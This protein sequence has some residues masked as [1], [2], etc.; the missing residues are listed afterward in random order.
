[1]SYQPKLYSNSKVDMEVAFDDLAEI[2]DMRKIDVER[3]FY[4][5]IT[6]FIG[7]EDYWISGDGLEIGEVKDRVFKISPDILDDMDVHGVENKRLVRVLKSTRD[8]SFQR[9]LF[10]AYLKDGKNGLMFAISKH[11]NKVRSRTRSSSGYK[12]LSKYEVKALYKQFINRLKRESAQRHKEWVNSILKANDNILYCEKISLTKDGQ[13]IL[14]PLLSKNRALSQLIVMV[15]NME[16]SKGEHVCFPVRMKRIPVFIR[17]A[18][19]RKKGKGEINMLR[20]DGAIMTKEVAQRHLD[21]LNGKIREEHGISANLSVVKI[22][23]RY[24]YLEYCSDYVLPL[25]ILK[26]VGKY[27]RSFNVTAFNNSN[28]R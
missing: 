6:Y 27:F 26:I 24:T 25:N 1:M 13:Y 19:I 23:N 4:D 28:V 21:V 11:K 17:P 16:N 20:S 8:R 14:K 18:R 3:V 15:K 22:T 9:V 10:D 5:A 2:Y 7:T 12:T